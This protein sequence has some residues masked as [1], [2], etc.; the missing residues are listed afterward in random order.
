ML[1]PLILSITVHEFCH[2]FAAD[3]LGDDLPARQG[4][5]TLNPMAHIDP[6]GTLLIPVVSMVLH[7]PLFGWGRPVETIPTAYTRKVSLRG[8]EALVSFAGP[9]AN[10][11]MAILCGGIWVGLTLYGVIDNG[12]PFYALLTQ[13]VTLNLALFFFNL[14][15]V[16]PLDG[17]KIVAWAVGYRADKT[18][19]MLAQLGPLAL[20]LAV[21]VLGSSI[22]WATYWAFGMII[23]GFARVLS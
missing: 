11:I 7:I 21:A 10:L 6:I 12:S 15:P 20:Y 22:S 5:L 23:D 2:A 19:D 13:M 9:L 8:G 14:L 18:L 17:S 3:R 16:P 1:V 4:R